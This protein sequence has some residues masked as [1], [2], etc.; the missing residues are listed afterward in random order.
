MP[1]KIP[2]IFDLMNEDEEA[3]NEEEERKKR[4][5]ELIEPTGVKEIFKD[6]KISIN[7]FTCVGGQC[8]LCIKACPTNALYWSIGEIGIIEDLCVYCNAC[9]ANCMVDDCIKVER[10]REDGTVEKVSKIS[11][12]IKLQEKKNTEKRFERV[13]TNAVILRHIY[14]EKDENGQTRKRRLLSYKI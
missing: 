1:T 10:T 14:K 13:K 9:V 5:K 2:S 12:I 7:K 4:R 11:N 8:E 6:G 3:A